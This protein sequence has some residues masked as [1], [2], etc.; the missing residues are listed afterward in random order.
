MRKLQLVFSALI[1]ATLVSLA[2]CARTKPNG[3]PHDAASPAATPVLSPA[4]KLI[5]PSELRK[6]RWIEGTWRGTGGDVPPFYERYRFENE[7]ALVV[8]TFADEKFTTV[9]DTSRFELKDG[10]FGHSEGE[11]GS[12]AT[13]FDDNSI[14][15]DP[16]GKGNSFRWQRESADSWKAVLNWIDKAGNPKERIYNMERWPAKK[17]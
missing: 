5:A 16:I 2:G 14:S 3:A 9:N 13:A 1:L 17:Q 12:V 4:P 11:S 15:F 7:S 6:L 10:H 8:E